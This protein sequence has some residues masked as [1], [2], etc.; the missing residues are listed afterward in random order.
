MV[1]L[2]NESYSVEKVKKILKI[3]HNLNNEKRCYVDKYTIYPN[4]SG[5]CHKCLLCAFYSRGHFSWK[6]KFCRW[7][8]GFCISIYT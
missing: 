5:I 8:I 4:N 6:F 7:R 1:K 3:Y 2:R